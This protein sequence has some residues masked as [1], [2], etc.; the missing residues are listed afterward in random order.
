MPADQIT[1]TGKVERTPYPWAT[2][3]GIKCCRLFLKM[4]D[5]MI[6]VLFIGELAE[7]AEQ[8]QFGDTITVSGYLSKFSQK[9][10]GCFEELRGMSFE[11]L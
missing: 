4:A 5:K 8:L 10:I 7:K 6:L 1:L 9:F 2:T 11:L 3:N